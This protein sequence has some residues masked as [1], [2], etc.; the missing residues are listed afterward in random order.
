MSETWKN[1]LE[2]DI[3]TWTGN[4]G[5]AYRNRAT[6]MIDQILGAGGVAASLGEAM[7]IV[8]DIVKTFRKMVQD[9][10]ASLLGALIGYTI[11]LALTLGGGAAHVIA[12]VYGRFARDGFKIS[13]L[14]VE[15]ASAF[16]DVNTLMQ[17]V[18]GVINALLGKQ[19]QPQTA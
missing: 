12:S 16:K 14:L 6:D 19:N 4:A 5:D 2:K 11:E 7:Q 9:I 13:M 1:G 3:A 15:M 8:A 17:A 18:M 10:L